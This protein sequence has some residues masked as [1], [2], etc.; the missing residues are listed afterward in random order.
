MSVPRA[1]NDDS[2]TPAKTPGKTDQMRIR[3]ATM[4]SA[5]SAFSGSKTTIPFDDT[6]DAM[7]VDRAHADH[8][9]AYFS[10]APYTMWYAAACARRSRSRSL[11]SHA[12]APREITRMGTEKNF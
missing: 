2:V 5:I 11:L 9:H 3:D 7:R 4:T 8:A 10:R 6:L 1:S 12:Q